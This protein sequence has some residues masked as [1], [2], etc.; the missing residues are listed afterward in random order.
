MRW[1]VDEEFIL[2]GVIVVCVKFVVWFF[3]EFCILLGWVIYFGDFD[4][5]FR[6]VVVEYK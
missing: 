2:F 3:G 1:N 4:L 5:F 6:V